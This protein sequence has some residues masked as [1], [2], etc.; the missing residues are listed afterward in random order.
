LRDDGEL[1]TRDIGSIVALNSSLTIL[2]QRHVVDVLLGMMLQVLGSGLTYDSLPQLMHLVSTYLEAEWGEASK[3]TTGS[4]ACPLRAGVRE[5]RYLFAVKACTLLLF[6]LQI[7]PS[8]PN[9]YESFAAC[10]G[11]VAGGASWILSAMVNSYC[12]TIRSLGVRCL[13]A[14]LEKTTKGPDA[15]LSLERPLTREL[16][17]SKKPD[18]HGLPTNTLSLISNVGQGILMSNVG[19]GLA[20]IG[21]S[22]R[23]AVLSPS[24]LTA[25]VV[26]KLLWHLLK[27]HRYRL[28]RSTQA[29]LIRLVFH[30][31]NAYSD[32]CRS[33]D[34][35][36]N[37]FL[38][39]DIALGDGVKIDTIWADKVL[40]DTTVRPSSAI[41]DSL[42]IGTIMRLLRYLPR[43][44]TD[45][46]LFILVN[47]TST[48]QSAVVILSACADW[49]PCLFQLIS[50]A[51]ERMSSFSLPPKPIKSSSNGESLANDGVDRSSPEKAF[52]SD[53][54]MSQETENKKDI[55]DR[56]ESSQPC[57]QFDLAVELY[58]ILLGHCIREDGE[59]VESIT[60]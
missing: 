19:R 5:E 18:N 60:I 50:E 13:V 2:E 12:D 34:F 48:S 8:I 49:Q 43:E 33:F 14:Y 24:K 10:C 36:K 32:S 56:R 55:D 7:Q 17:K 21:P 11:S 20:A 45:Q 44:L 40:T 58:A 25:G 1:F 37:N 47:V 38:I 46:W 53:A 41:R 23:A 42:S 28:T 57:E 6:L 54:S 27:S 9:L 35:L 22:V 30:D 3:E 16:D 4:R 26:Y 52:R 29:S 59:K 39:P 15:P 51:A 31:G